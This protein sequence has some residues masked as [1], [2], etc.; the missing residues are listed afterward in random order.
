MWDHVQVK[1]YHPPSPPVS[2]SLDQETPREQGEGRGRCWSSPGP[3][4]LAG[5]SHGSDPSDMTLGLSQLMDHPSSRGTP[6]SEHQSQR[7]FHPTTMELGGQG[8]GGT[9]KGKWE[10]GG[11]EHVLLSEKKL[12]GRYSWIPHTHL[13]GRLQLLL[14]SRSVAFSTIDSRWKKGTLVRHVPPIGC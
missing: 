14:H 10:R 5:F 9:R 2:M 11:G 3:S 8:K 6:L 12:Q 7:L 1:L 4:A 13:S